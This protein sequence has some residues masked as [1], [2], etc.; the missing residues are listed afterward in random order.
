MKNLM[1]LD[2]TTQEVVDTARV[3]QKLV[4]R[5]TASINEEIPRL[6]LGYMLRDRTGHVVWGTNT[7][8]TRQV[9][10]DLKKGDEVE[11]RLN[12][13]CT[14]GPGSYSFSPALVSS[15]THLENNY[16]W[17]DNALVF[18]VVNADKGYFIGTSWLDAV[19]QISR[20]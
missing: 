20:R 1:L 5:L 3:G 12:F 8:H 9:I 2:E 10:K 6:V 4:L 13:T 18:D 19:F 15:D 14:L 16:E 7:W 17:V 11:F